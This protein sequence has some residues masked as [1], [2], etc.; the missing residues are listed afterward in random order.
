MSDNNI[1]YVQDIYELAKGGVTELAYKLECHPRTIER[2]VKYGIPDRFWA[3]LHKLYGVTPF[4][5]FR[6]NAKIR[7]YSSKILSK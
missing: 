6:L 3:P 5:L 4:E 2:W 1:K 7:G